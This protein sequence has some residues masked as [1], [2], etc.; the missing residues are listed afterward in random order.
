MF[1]SFAVNNNVIASCKGL[2]MH[3]VTKV[4]LLKILP[5]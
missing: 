4:L 1:E 3:F 2:T 5:Q